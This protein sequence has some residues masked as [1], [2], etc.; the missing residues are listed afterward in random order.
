MRR[1]PGT[2]V[3]DDDGTGVPH[4]RCTAARCALR[5]APRA[6]LALAALLIGVGP[7]C[8]HDVVAGVGGFYGGLIHPLL[9]PAHGLALAALGLLIGQQ[10]PRAGL[11]AVFAAALLL[12]VIVIVSAFAARDVDYAI[13]GIAAAAGVAVAIARPLSVVVSCPLAAVAG[14]AIELDSVPQGISMQ[15]TFLAL[16]GTAVGA[17]L[18]VMFLADLAVCLQRDWQRIGARV[19]GSWIAASAILVLALRLSR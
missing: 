16:A 9:V 13:L 8:A 4:L 12:G 7:A 11:K 19:A 2:P 1:R 10:T 3:V 15:T 18:V 14:V 17:F 6:G 5:A